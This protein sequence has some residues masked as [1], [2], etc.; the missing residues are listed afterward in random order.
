M[1]FVTI[2]K[3][4]PRINDNDPPQKKIPNDKVKATGIKHPVCVAEILASA[5]RPA[6]PRDFSSGSM[7]ENRVTPL[8]GCL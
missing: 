1:R 7:V 2:I 5:H 3:R 6:Q 4:I 8:R